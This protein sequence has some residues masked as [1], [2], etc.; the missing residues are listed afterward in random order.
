MT[1]VHVMRLHLPQLDLAR[2]H[3]AII[4]VDTHLS[5]MQTCC[6]QREQAFDSHDSAATRDALEDLVLQII[7]I[8]YVKAVDR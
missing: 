1:A 5:N 4:A 6:L 2:A 8:Q 3:V 7:L